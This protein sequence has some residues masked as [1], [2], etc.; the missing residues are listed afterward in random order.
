MLPYLNRRAHLLTA[1][2][3]LLMVLLYMSCKKIHSSDTST[4]Q[5]NPVSA[6]STHK[7]STHPLPKELSVKVTASVSGFVVSGGQGTGEAVEGAQ[8]SFGNKTTQTDRDGYFEIKNATVSKVAAQITASKAGF[9][10]AYKTVITQGGESNFERLLLRYLPGGGGNT[11]SPLYFDG[12][13]YTISIPPN[14]FVIKGTKTIF[15]GYYFFY[16]NLDQNDNGN[17]NIEMPGD[18]RGIDSVGKLKLLTTKDLVWCYAEGMNGEQLELSSPATISIRS[19]ITTRLPAWRYDETVGL[20]IQESSALPNSYGLECTIDKLG[21]WNFATSTDYTTVSAKLV[22]NS[23]EPIPFAYVRIGGNDDLNATQLFKYTD[24]EGYINIAAPANKSLSFDIH[25]DGYETPIASKK[26]D[27]ANSDLPLGDIPVNT[28]DVYTISGSIVSCSGTP[29]SNGFLMVNELRF[30]TDLNG[31]VHFSTIIKNLG[32]Y[33]N[34]GVVFAEEIP[35]LQKSDRLTLNLVP[36]NNDIGTISVCGKYETVKV[37]AKLVDN[38]GNPLPNLFVRITPQ[39]EPQSSFA[40]TSDS[41]GNIITSTYENRINQLQVYG[42]LNCGTPVYSATFSTTNRDT[43]LGSIAINGVITANL[44]GSVVDCNNNPI[45]SGSVIVQ[46]D[47]KNYRFPINTNGTFA[48]NIPICNTTDPEAVTV[49]AEDNVSS[50]TGNAVNFSINDGNN[51][52]GTIR[53]CSNNSTIEFMN[54]SIDSTPYSLVAPVDTFTEWVDPALHWTGITGW[55]I[56]N[57]VP[58]VHFYL[59]GAISVGSKEV[60]IDEFDIGDNYGRYADSTTAAPVVNITEYGP[61]GGYISGN[62]KVKI[63]SLADHSVHDATC[64]FRVKRNE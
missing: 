57:S 34:P 2:I 54:Y 17:I 10:T 4:T 61:V 3:F 33:T 18:S 12:N 63:E 40:S 37:T 6:D 44:A 24:A 48:F 39:S 62:I 49:F 59:T 60:S 51:I 30:P 31:K 8:I 9:F 25:A 22:T 28:N 19:A 64:S 36:G 20:F 11:A 23:G 45:I 13:Y 14:A 29:V 56:Y 26:F 47:N 32:I 58:S 52:L 42:S 1:S 46:K 21:I 41:Q 43:S 15:S 53:A 16:S 5:P 38:A 27:N 7:D 55:N 35:T 50:E